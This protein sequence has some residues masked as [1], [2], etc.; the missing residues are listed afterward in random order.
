[1][2]Y[3]DRYEVIKNVY[4]PSVD[5]KFPSHV[6]YGKQR[7]FSHAWLRDHS[8]WLVYSKV[9]DGGFCLP[10]VLFARPQANVDVGVLVTKPLTTFNKATEI[11][12]KH[13]SQLKYHKNAMIDMHNFM[14][15]MEQR[16]QSVYELAHTSHARLV[17]QNRLKLKSI[18]KCVIWCG[19]QNIALRGHRDDDKQL[20]QDSKGNPGYNFVW[21]QVTSF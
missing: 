6:D 7:R 5:F 10:C 16:Q 20:R 12:R 14:H 17:A 18:L 2:Y 13:S 11:C 19:K 1:M 9:L 4:V 21:N 8:P 15:R 3:F